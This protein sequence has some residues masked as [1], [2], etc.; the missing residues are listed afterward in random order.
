[1]AWKQDLDVNKLIRL[2]KEFSE[3]YGG[4]CGIS[5]Q[6]VQI[7][8]DVMEQVAPLDEWTL[9]KKRD[10]ATFPFEHFIMRDG[11]KFM[12]ITDEKL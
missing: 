4:M 3:E 5:Q 9:N 10:C 2:Q 12:S 1:M 7:R 11:V 8:H 6:C